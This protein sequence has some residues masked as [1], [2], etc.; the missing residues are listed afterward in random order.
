M[1]AQSAQLEQLAHAASVA[2]FL[3]A[4]PDHPAAG[5]DAWAV[6]YADVLRRVVY[7]Q[8]AQAPRSLQIH[9]GPSELGVN[10]DRQVAGKLARLAPTNHVADPWA[11][12]LGTATHAWL[13][14]A[15]TADN[16]RTGVLRWIAEQRVEPHP[17]HSGTA[18]LYDAVEQAVVDHKVLGKTTHAK[19]REQGAPRKY[20]VQLLLYGWGY[21]KLG[22]PVRRVAIAAY[23]RTEHR[24]DNLYVWSTPFSDDQGEILPE[25][26][27]LLV[28]VF[29]DTE[30][31]KQYARQLLDGQLGL[32]DVPPAPDDTDCY[33]CPFYRP[34]SA[35]DG[36]AGCP[37]PRKGPHSNTPSF[38]VEPA[39]RRDQPAMP[40]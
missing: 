27:D 13:A 22:L 18:D 33:F 9:L 35:Q 34:Q 2:E 38:P 24:L 16:T 6:R 40:Q 29:T 3:G 20:H 5:N 32:L 31:R 1:T 12:I 8:A 28:E 30:R 15:F 19:L 36:G 10:C 4:A 25:V 11:S 7:D 14:D 23:P 21:R 37:G 39:G 26:V 17:E